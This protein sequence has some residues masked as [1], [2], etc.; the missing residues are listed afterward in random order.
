MGGSFTEPDLFVAGNN[1]GNFLVT[2][3]AGDVSANAQ[4]VIS[5]AEEPSGVPP[6][7]P[8]TG[9]SRLTCLGEVP[10]QE[11]MNF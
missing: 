10:P 2:V 6:T 4:V 7:V 3:V 11:W 5:S 8:G 1:E 9:I